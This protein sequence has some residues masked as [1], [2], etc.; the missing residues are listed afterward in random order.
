[1]A[2]NVVKNNFEVGLARFQRFPRG[3]IKVFPTKGVIIKMFAFLS[4]F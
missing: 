1:M 4:V 2:H 3:K